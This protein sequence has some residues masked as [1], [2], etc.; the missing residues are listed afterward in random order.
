MSLRPRRLRT[1]LVLAL[2]GTSSRRS[3]PRPSRSSRRSSTGS[4]ATSSTS[5]ASSRA[6]RASASASC[7][8]PPAP[9]LAARAPLVRD[10]RARA[11]G[12]VALLAAD[13]GSLADTDPDEGPS[14]ADRAGCRA[15][16]TCA[17]ASRRRRGR[18][19]G[20]RAR[21]GEHVTLVI[22]K[23][24]GDTRA[25]PRPSAARCRSPP[26]SGCSPASRS[27]RSP[28]AAC[29]AACGGCATTRAPC[30]T[31]ASSTIRWTRRPQDEVGEV[32]GAGPEAVRQ[33]GLAAD[34]A[35]A[36]HVRQRL[37]HRDH[38]LGAPG[39]DSGVN[40]VI[41]ALANQVAHGV[42]GDHDF[43]GRVTAAVADGR[44]KLLG[45][46]RQQRQRELLTNLLLVAGRERIQ[47]ARDGLR[48]VIGMQAWRAPGARFRR[49]SARWP[50]SPDPASRRPE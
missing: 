29:C 46:D 40:L 26:S 43:E 18:P 34:P 22:R 37:L 23:P 20:R 6:P 48:G 36:H 50:W 4:S 30:T 17:R 21:G 2:V 47:N 39:G 12:A 27:P 5:C 28:P 44:N 38:P 7:P 3:W 45:D 35:G 14:G 1:R 41:L 16:A 8:R 31:R 42:C 49:P 15:T 32:A 11:G 33:S 9:G 19:R 13:G 24:L 25:P 10:L